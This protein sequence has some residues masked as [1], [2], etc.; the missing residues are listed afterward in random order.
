MNFEIISKT[1]VPKICFC[2]LKCSYSL[3]CIMVSEIPSRILEYRKTFPGVHKVIFNS[4]NIFWKKFSCLYFLHVQLKSS[5]SFF[6]QFG[7][8]VL[9]CRDINIT[10]MIQVVVLLYS[11]YYINASYLYLYGYP[12]C[13]YLYIFLIF[14][15][16]YGYLQVSTK[17]K[18]LIFNNILTVN[19]NKNTMHNI[20][21]FQTKCK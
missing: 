2:I 21:R 18:T 4:K 1:P 15:D 16:I 10:D 20:H 13:G 3:K 19:S 8:D 12:L 14:T 11:T 5:I 6:H 7:M 9:I 17:E